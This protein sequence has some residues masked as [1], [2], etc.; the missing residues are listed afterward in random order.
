ML[1]EKV[2]EA[3]VN[4]NEAMERIMAWAAASKLGIAPDKSTTILITSDPHQFRHHPQ[5]YIDGNQIPL[6]R[7][8]KILG[9]TFDYQLR[10]N[11]HADNVV[12]S[13]SSR[14]QILKALAG[15]S[16]GQNKEL[17]LLTY[18]ALVL[19]VIL[20]AA[21]IWYPNVSATNI[22]R[23]QRVQ[24]E[25]LRIITGC[26]RMSCVD[27][28]HS[29]CK[30]LKVESHLNLVAS[31]F[32]ANAKKVS[33]VSHEVVADRRLPRRLRHTLQSKADDRVAPFLVNGVL[34]PEKYKQTI[35]SLHSATVIAEIDAQTPNRV[36]GVNPPP[37]ISVNEARLG[38]SS[39]SNS[40]RSASIGFPCYVA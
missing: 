21:P 6:E 2:E 37:N 35:T 24:N 10:F 34:P 36:L 26:H 25:A 29:E 11:V 19:P 16:W 18:K 22:L 14:L 27:H 4:V 39:P 38:R 15:T 28:L 20:Y 1:E 30:I 3:E 12:A 7:F 33:H 5:V 13:A 23:L 9:V 40:S 31:Q 8:P 17:L 32:L